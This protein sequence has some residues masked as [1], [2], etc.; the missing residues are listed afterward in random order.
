MGAGTLRLYKQGSTSKHLHARRA[1]AVV[2]L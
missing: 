1:A 2:L